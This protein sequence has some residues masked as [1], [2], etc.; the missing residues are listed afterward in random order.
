MG[1]GGHHLWADTPRE[2]AKKPLT[3]AHSKEQVMLLKDAKTADQI[4][5]ATGGS[6]FFHSRAMKNRIAK[7]E[8][9]ENI[10]KDNCTTNTTIISL[11][12]DS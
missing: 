10:K 5:H 12:Q 11:Y 1:F 3:E 4:F 8:Q 2:P 7:I 6:D 9:L